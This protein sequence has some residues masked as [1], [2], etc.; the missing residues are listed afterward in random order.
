MQGESA[1]VANPYRSLLA[2]RDQRHGLLRTRH[3]DLP[4]APCQPVSDAAQATG[5]ATRSTEFAA[6]AAHSTPPTLAAAFNN[7]GAQPDAQYS[8]VPILGKATAQVSLLVGLAIALAMHGLISAWPAHA[9]SAIG[10]NRANDALEANAGV[11]ASGLP[12]APRVG[13]NE[14]P[15]PAPTGA[16]A[17]RA[18]VGSVSIVPAVPG[19]DRDAAGGTDTSPEGTS[20]RPA[21]IAPHRGNGSAAALTTRSVPV[22]DP[23]ADAD[24]VA[25]L[26]PSGAPIMVLALRDQAEGMGA[27]VQEGQGPPVWI[28][29]GHAF[30]SGWEAVG[31]AVDQVILLSPFGRV[32]RVPVSQPGF[33]PLAT[34]NG[35]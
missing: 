23:L 13:R 28:H 22:S 5:Q 14:L 35:Q 29:A 6:I 1:A 7:D 32:V 8:I 19:A 27:L 26:A 33:A 21:A 4:A 10:A 17:A 12:R 15:K 31:I 3:D 20:G 2:E 16:S 30:A 24:I 11:S 25:E 18:Q 9:G 34:V